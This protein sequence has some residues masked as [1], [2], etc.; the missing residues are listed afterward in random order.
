MGGRKNSF[1]EKLFD[2]LLRL[3]DGRRLGE[4]HKIDKHKVLKIFGLILMLN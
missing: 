3:K 2:V 1:G 4:V